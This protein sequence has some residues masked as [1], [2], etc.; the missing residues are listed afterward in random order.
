MRTCSQPGRRIGATMAFATDRFTSSVDELRFGPLRIGL[1]DLATGAIRPLDERSTAAAV[2]EGDQPAVVAGW[3]RA[4]YIADL[5]RASNVYRRT[6]RPGE[7]VQV[8]NEQA[9]QRHHATS[10][11]LAVARRQRNDSRSRRSPAVRC[12]DS[13]R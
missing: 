3:Q 11:A 4:L 6:W 12:M 9:D 8:T 10:P 7:L 13:D 2:R 1:L 5:E